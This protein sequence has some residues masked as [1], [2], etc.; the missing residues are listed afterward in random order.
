MKLFIFAGTAAP[1][2]SRRAGSPASPRPPSRCLQVGARRPLGSRPPQ[3]FR[4]GLLPP[5]IHL[6]GTSAFSFIDGVKK[7]ESDNMELMTKQAVLE[8]N[9]MKQSAEAHGTIK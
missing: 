1:Y 5:P 2:P 3:S 8:G 7:H 9:I 6:H 4:A